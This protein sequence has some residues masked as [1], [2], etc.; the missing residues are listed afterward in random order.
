MAPG[1][2]GGRLRKDVSAEIV[3]EKTV[4]ALRHMQAEVCDLNG[5]R[6]IISSCIAAPRPRNVSRSRGEEEHSIRC[7]E[8]RFWLSKTRSAS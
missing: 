8:R 4:A 1:G 6:M 5:A 2:K 7:R 3:G